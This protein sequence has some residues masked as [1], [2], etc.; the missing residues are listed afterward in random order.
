VGRWWVTLSSLA[1]SG[2]LLTAA[3]DPR[4]LNKMRA[5]R[6]MV[7]AGLCDVR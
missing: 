7:F 3:G 1:A 6:A 4:A 2:F 5:L